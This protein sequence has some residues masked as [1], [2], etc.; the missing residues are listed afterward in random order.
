MIQVRLISIFYFCYLTF[1]FNCYRSFICIV[2]VDILF[3]VT[4][5]FV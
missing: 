2:I 1:R 5:I 3:F 4:L